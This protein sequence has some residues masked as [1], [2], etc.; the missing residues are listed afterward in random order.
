MTQNQDKMSVQELIERLS[1]R[2]TGIDCTGLTGASAAYLVSRLRAELDMPIFLV[3]SSQ[4]AIDN[5]AEDLRFF[6]PPPA[7]P[8]SI[9]PAY[10]ISPFKFIA[11]HNE[12]AAKRIETLYRLVAADASPLVITSIE[13][14]LQKVIP[15]R[16]LVNFAELIMAGEGCERDRLVEKL[17]AGGYNR[18]AIVEE[19]GDFCVRG[20]ILDV[21][22][23]GY[24]EPVRIEFFGDTVDTIR[25]FSAA[26]Q[27][28]IRDLPEAVILPAREAIL[29]AE[30][31]VAVIARIRQE[32]AKLEMPVT[33]V[34]KIVDRIKHEGVFPGA[35]GLLPLIFPELSSL[36]DYAPPGALFVLVDTED[37]ERQ[38]MGTLE[39]ARN[40]TLEAKNS[41]R[42]CVE[43]EQM[44]LSWEQTQQMLDQRK[45]L[46]LRMFAV[47]GKGVSGPEPLSIGRFAVTDNSALQT[48]LKH[49][50]VK[51]NL[52]APLVDWIED[53]RQTGSRTLIVCR[54]KSRG[55]RLQSI[56]I[57]Y[58]VK[59]EFAESPAES[60]GDK[61]TVF[62]VLGRISGGFAWPDEQL[63][64]ITEEEI[65][66]SR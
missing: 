1:G 40:N 35:E 30:N 52:F 25:V 36:F 20:M 63:A 57:P 22:S 6:L 2:S 42:L 13:A 27:R 29:Q 44:F 34:R 56:L 31:R 9:F 49:Q 26:T 45:P 53:K 46:R 18:T 14:L 55:E 54:S 66:G 33:R 4:K 61:E 28:K 21:F 10:N 64:V 58:G 38:A 23:P 47:L 43:P 39:R 50:E 16:E 62:T 37:L 51:E 48:E 60:S 17:V 59:T 41:G 19:P 7:R 24:P 65:F 32:A 3:T 5:L 15:R 12:T 8:A 11:Y